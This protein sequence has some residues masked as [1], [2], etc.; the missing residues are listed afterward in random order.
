[1][2]YNPQ[3]DQN[4]LI[5]LLAL[6][7]CIEPHYLLKLSRTKTQ[8]EMS[9]VIILITFFWIKKTIIF[10]S[11]ILIKVLHGHLYLDNI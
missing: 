7:L 9:G 5:A 4:G 10:Y 11:L 8:S 2:F 3:F 1:M 6:V